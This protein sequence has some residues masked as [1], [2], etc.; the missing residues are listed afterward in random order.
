[1]MKNKWKV[2]FFGLLALII[3]AF[4]ALFVVVTSSSEDQA[5]PKNLTQ[6]DGSEVTVNATANDFETL[7]NHFIS[8]ATADTQMP[9]KMFVD[10]DIT[11][12]SKVSV[13]GATLPVTMDFEPS[14]DDKG[15]LILEQTSIEIGRLNIP[16]TTAL[17][18]VKDSG[19]LPDFITIQPSKN[20]AY[21][22]L[23]AIRIP[24]SKKVDAHLRAT[25]FDLTNDEIELKVI[26][27]SKE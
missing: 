20:Q 27:P 4:V 18:L 13:L 11:L 25:K 1:M 10:K 19:K 23:N 9:M 24:I 12:T 7:A 26:I 15:N 3:M 14:I 8:D 2:A 5:I 16:P 17:K 6:I 21:I 22:N